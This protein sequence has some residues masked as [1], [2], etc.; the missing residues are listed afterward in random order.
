MHP[1]VKRLLSFLTTIDY[2]KIIISACFPFYYLAE[3]KTTSIISATITVNKWN[4]TEITT[5]DLFLN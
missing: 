2:I 3:T 5:H 4:T 1:V